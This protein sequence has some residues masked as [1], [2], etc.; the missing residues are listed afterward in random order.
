MKA[1]VIRQP[2]DARDVLELKM[3]WPTP[4]SPKGGDIVIRISYAALNPLDI[5]VMHMRRPWVRDPIPGADFVGEVVQAGPSSSVREGTIV[6]GTIPTMRI[7][8]SGGT[9]AEYVSLPSHMVA[10]KPQGLAE[11]SAV[12]IMGV[13]GQTS[14]IVLR[15]ANLQPGDKVLVNG[16]SG[17]VGCVLMQVLRAKGMHVTAVCSKKNDALVRRLGAEDVSDGLPRPW[18]QQ[19]CLTIPF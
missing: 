16:A 10:A 9:L 17:G 13:P 8:S 4:P 3:D 1:W 14:A 12:A 2:G 5:V 6:S 11:D 19:T 7:M 18:E 15:G